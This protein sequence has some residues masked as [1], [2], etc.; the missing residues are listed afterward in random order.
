MRDLKSKL[1]LYREGLIDKEYDYMT[2]FKSKTSQFYGIPKIHKSEKI[3]NACRIATDIIIKVPTPYDLKLRLI[4][5]GPACETHRLNNF[6]DA[7]LKP[8]LKNVKSYIRDD[9][10]MLN[11]LPE[12]INKSTLLVSVDVL[13][14]YSNIPHNL[15]I[16]VIQFWLE[17][18]ANELPHRIKKEF[19]IEGLKFSP[20]NNYFVFKDNFYQHKSG[21]AMGTRMAPSF[22]N[23]VMGYLEISLYR[24]ILEKYSSPFSIYIENN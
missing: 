17:N 19:V 14:L 2:N 18:Y 6:L 13:N 10:D 4:I 21:T 12:T 1:N 16:E 8:F 5:A 9:L 24:K 15:G 11:H 20:E 7:L 23:L 22:A 3:S